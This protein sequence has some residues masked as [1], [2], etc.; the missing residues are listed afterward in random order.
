MAC[1]LAQL[2]RL[3]PSGDVPDANQAVIIAPP[4][5]LHSGKPPVVFSSEEFSPSPE[6]GLEWCRF[7]QLSP[8][9]YGI[10]P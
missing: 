1:G 5:L 3:L 9:N 6:G 2:R 7:A 10:S 4:P 8:L